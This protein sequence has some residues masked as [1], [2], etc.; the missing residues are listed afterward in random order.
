MTKLDVRRD[1]PTQFFYVLYVTFTV[2][3]YIVFIIV[4]VC[5]SIRPGLA[6]ISGNIADSKVIQVLYVTLVGIFITVSVYLIRIH[7][8]QSFSGDNEKLQDFFK[9]RAG[10]QF[11][12]LSIRNLFLLLIGV[13]SIREYFV[14]HMVIAGCAIA[15]IWVV[16]VFMFG[17]RYEMFEKLKQIEEEEEGLLAFGLK[18][19]LSALFRR[20]CQNNDME[21]YHEM[22]LFRGMI[23]Q[24]SAK[25]YNPKGRKKEI[26][27][28]QLERQGKRVMI[29]NLIC[30]GLIVLLFILFIILGPYRGQVAE[31]T[32]NI[33]IV[34]YLAFGLG[35]PLMAIF[36]AVEIHT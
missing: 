20:Y 4:M 29:A 1:R 15:S 10:W 2:I 6:S 22:D 16:E 11:I 30:I 24:L 36:H 5:L 9:A 21:M 25:S 23:R 3:L 14:A 27:L 8:E 34:E 7:V 13:V 33:A 12:L 32:T 28:I 31:E 19:D 17:V 35:V 18:R 26:V